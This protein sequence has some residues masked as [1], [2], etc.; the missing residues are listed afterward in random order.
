MTLPLPPLWTGLRFSP[1]PAQ[2]RAVGHRIP[3]AAGVTVEFR[4]DA[5]ARLAS[6]RLPDSPD[7]AAILGWPT[8]FSFVRILMP[9]TALDTLLGRYGVIQGEVELRMGSGG[10]PVRAEWLA[11]LRREGL[12]GLGDHQ[13]IS[14]APVFAE[15]RTL[16]LPFLLRA[17]ER[18]APG[19]V[20]LALQLP[21]DAAELHLW[22]F[23]LRITGFSSAR[24]QLRLEPGAILAGEVTQ[25]GRGA[26]LWLG[27]RHAAAG[28]LEAP[29]ADGAFA[30]GFDSGRMERE[31]GDAA[32][33]A[34]VAGQETLAYLDLA[35][36]PAAAGALRTLLRL[37][38]PGGSAPDEA[39]IAAGIAA[40]KGLHAMHDSTAI[41]RV[42]AGSAM[43]RDGRGPNNAFEAYL[44]Y[45]HAR[46]HLDMNGT[47]TAAASFAVLDPVAERYLAPDDLRHARLAQA[48]ACLRSGAATEA[49]AILEALRVARPTDAE[50]Y[51]QLANSLRAR[52]PALRRTWLRVAEVL[53][54]AP[55]IGLVTAILAELVAAGQA[56]EALLRCLPAL[57][58]ERPDQ[59][60]WL[61]LA[62]IQI[63]R[64]D[65]P[66]WAAS[67]ARF[68]RGHGMAP[69]EFGALEGPDADAFAA[70]GA[71]A[72]RPSLPV[73][74]PL[75]VIAMTAYNAAATLETAAR[76]V[77]AQSHTNLRLVIVD[78]ASTDA[79]PAIIERLAEA[80]VRVAVL[81]NATNMGTYGAKNRV[82][83]EYPGE[84]HG[85][86]DSDDWMHPDYVAEHLTRMTKHPEAL[87]T[88]SSWYR[89]DRAGRLGVL[90]AGGYLHENPASTFIAR[91]VVERMGFFD[92]VRTGA[93]SEFL[94]RMR[95]RFGRG[96]VIAIRKPLAI[97][98]LR[99][100]SLTQN[101]TTGFDEDRFSPVRSRYWE[102]W[103]RWHRE[104][105]LASG[106]QPLFMPFPA[107][108]RL[109]PAPAE[110]LP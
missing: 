52:D 77:L 35:A 22:Q 68:F 96:A 54:P 16:R 85:F 95:R 101:R 8:L 80:D 28:V 65:R 103:I 3:F 21:A 10:P 46:S 106:G 41:W 7:G 78:D 29:L 57:Q 53:H 55:P 48:Q 1:N 99:S 50:V 110:I 67:V 40:L 71:T 82:L 94:W 14:H 38:D 56:E 17:P 72:R 70:L 6:V 98:L 45:L 26:T 15:A 11:L 36:G 62:Q 60:L 92:T 89:M 9:V 47:A 2:V 58:G 43:A 108:V 37:A 5:E 81:R 33:A 83:A 93:D 91:E 76:S 69:P 64:G 75:V 18:L 105:L 63:A 51:F 74:G 104:A 100:D 34:L 61:A 25:A 88:T 24:N 86:H 42:H 84:F 66:G 4:S 27:A 59:D 49:V 12:H 87:C 79:T 97:G 23:G 31:A 90:W 107:P 19:G 30:I 109:F 32:C 73:P 20:V 39:A 44:L 13:V 102:S